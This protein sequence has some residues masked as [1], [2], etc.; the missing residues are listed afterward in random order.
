MRL[1]LSSTHS[2]GAARG[3]VR[4]GRAGAAVADA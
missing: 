4:R 3:A 2:A 1:E